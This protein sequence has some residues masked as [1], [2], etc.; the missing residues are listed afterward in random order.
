M[1]RKKTKSY[2]KQAN[3]YRSARKLCEKLR[4]FRDQWVL[5]L[6]NALS[7]ENAF[8]LEYMFSRTMVCNLT[9][10]GR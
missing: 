6:S 3:T 1:C 8:T 10:N 4:R 7:Q 2:G 5:T 9:S